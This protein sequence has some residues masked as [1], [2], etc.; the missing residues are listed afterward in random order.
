MIDNV[1]MQMLQFLGGLI[2]HIVMNSGHAVTVHN[3]SE[4]NFQL[5]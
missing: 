1:C 3:G 5:T 2:E 4:L